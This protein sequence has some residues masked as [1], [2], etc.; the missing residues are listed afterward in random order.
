[1]GN[2]RD[3]FWCGRALNGCLAAGLC[4]MKRVGKEYTLE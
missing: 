2:E 4:N 1:M 3:Y